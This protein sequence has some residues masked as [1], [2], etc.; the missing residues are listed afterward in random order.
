MMSLNS[1][2]QKLPVSN[3]ASRSVISA[4]ARLEDS[5]VTSK[6]SPKSPSHGGESEKNKKYDRQLRLWGETGQAAIE[7]SHVCLINATCTGVEILKSLILPGIGSFTIVDD[8]VVTDSDVG[9]N[10]FLT[11][12]CIGSSR[13]K[14]TSRLLNELN[15]DVRGDYVEE[16][17]EKLLDSSVHH[18]DVF[19][20]YSLVI[21]C[22]LKN[23]NSLLKLSNM[24]WDKNIPL[25]IVK[26]NGMYGY[27]R[28]QVKEH[29][30]IESHPDSVLEDLRLGDPFPGMFYASLC[31]FDRY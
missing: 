22:N 4:M 30:V 21:A 3:L 18:H 31:F 10:F 20:G 14:V 9:C 24:L 15:P 7:S 23:E 28:L 26:T 8:H 19:S 6:P 27:L 12:S 17:L 1:R 11:D 29:D 2:Q 13:G 5:P 16:S 25:V